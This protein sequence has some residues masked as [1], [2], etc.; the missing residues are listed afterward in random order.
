MQMIFSGLGS[1]GRIDLETGLP[2]AAAS[3]SL[4]L[5]A[6]L[7]DH[8]AHDVLG[9][10]RGVLTT[11]LTSTFVVHDYAKFE[12]VEEASFMGAP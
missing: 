8:A 6:E 3:A 11:S 9:P 4:P 12:I 5:A 10:S 7:L 2:V 1:G